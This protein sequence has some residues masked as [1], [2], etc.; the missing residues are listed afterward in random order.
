MYIIGQENS[1][2]AMHILRMRMKSPEH[3]ER[4]SYGA[5]VLGGHRM[6]KGKPELGA[7]RVLSTPLTRSLQRS[8]PEGSCAPSPFTI[9]LRG[10]PS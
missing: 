1:S 3:S 10:H 5:E 9:D 6:M 8:L 7:C 2:E 4:R